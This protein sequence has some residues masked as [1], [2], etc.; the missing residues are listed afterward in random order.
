MNQ[1]DKTKQLMKIVIGAAWID[2]IIQEEERE[3]LKK[4]AQEKGLNDDPEIKSLLSE[5]KSVSHQECYTWLEEYLGQNHQKKDYQNLLEAISG[6]VYSD[7]NIDVQ[8]ARLLNQIENFDPENQTPQSIFT[9]L[10]SSVKKIY[11][12]AL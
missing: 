6:L 2:G 3:Y 1:A 9:Y 7:G 10:L 4:M 8:E 12:K 5:I 11:R